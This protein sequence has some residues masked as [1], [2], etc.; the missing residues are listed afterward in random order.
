M[1]RCPA[2]V[3]AHEADVT[4][5][6]HDDRKFLTRFSL[7]VVGLAVFTVLIILA[8]LHF[9]RQMS[10]SEN[11]AR[12]VAREQRLAPVG[13]VFTGETGRAAALA[14]AEAARPR[15]PALAFDGSL[16]GQLIYQN[17]CQACHMAGAAGA[18]LLTTAAWADRIDKG[19]STLVA[20]AIAGIGAMPPRGGR[21]DLSDEQIEATVEWILEQVR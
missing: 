13:G 3:Y 10:V 21:S 7:V 8:A 11:P 6:E 19:Q 16:D 4:V 9:Q 1:N 17:A 15:A 14:A 20:N 18:P 5:S 2:V 12:E